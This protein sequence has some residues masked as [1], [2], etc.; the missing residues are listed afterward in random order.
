MSGAR[1]VPD[2]LAV[3]PGLDGPESPAFEAALRTAARRLVSEPLPSAG[4]LGVTGAGE[5]HDA[6]RPR[7]LL[8]LLAGL[9]ATVVALAAFQGP[10]RGV[11]AGVGG[12]AASAGAT[13]SV[14]LSPTPAPT[15]GP[16]Q[17][18]AP[19]A[20]PSPVPTVSTS[21]D[22]A[23]AFAIAA[24]T[25]V[26]TGLGPVTSR[27]ADKVALVRAGPVLGKAFGLC[28]AAELA[29]VNAGQTLTFTV[30]AVGSP[31]PRIVKSALIADVA[32][33][34]AVLCRDASLA[35]TRT[36]VSLPDLLAG[37]PSPSLSP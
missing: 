33:V 16:S 36:C 32:G 8:P 23:T 4:R 15:V 34:A 19:S 24:K 9:A 18:A 26:G 11:P 35:T 1:G 31:S 28:S 5:P 3:V 27:P 17:S 25:W 10:L 13:S 21:A 30:K 14:I 2:G 22:C 12:P 20:T 7:L 29:N 37:A 6:R